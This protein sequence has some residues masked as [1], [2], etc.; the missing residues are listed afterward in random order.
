MAARSGRIEKR[1]QLSLPVQISN[2]YDPSTT[3]RTTTENVCSLGM[4]ILTQK[5]RELNERLMINSLAG[6]LRA[7]ARVVYCQRLSD[8]RFGVGIQFQGQS[9]NWQG[10]SLAGATH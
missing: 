3:E 5:A 1:I 6:D 2:L 10:G 7:L 8:G 9:V 4:R